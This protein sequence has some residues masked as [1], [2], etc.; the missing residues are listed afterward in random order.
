MLSPVPC[1]LNNQP[2]SA[3]GGPGGKGA[4]KKT[5]KARNTGS[6]EA[7][8]AMPLWGR[9]GTARASSVARYAAA[10]PGSACPRRRRVRFCRLG[11]N[12]AAARGI[13]LHPMRRRP[14][15]CSLSNSSRWPNLPRSTAP[16]ASPTSRT[17]AVVPRLARW[18]L[19]RAP[20]PDD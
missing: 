17:D 9:C 4:K 14:F 15:Q 18:S 11:S 1:S 12:R 8:S 3:D 13:Q 5:K 10:R 2:E 20:K 6:A 16:E 7:A 19:A